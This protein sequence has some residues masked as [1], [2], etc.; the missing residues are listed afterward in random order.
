MVNFIVCEDEKVLRNET[1]DI[2]DSLMMNYDI[3]YKIN[4]FDGYNNKFEEI[5]KKDTG[6]KIYL[7]D[8]KTKKGSGIDAARIIREQYDDWNS[9]IILI[10]SYSEYKYEALCS[11]LFLLDYIN[12]L[13]NCQK[14]IKEDLVIAMKHYDNKCNM[15]SYEYNHIYY[16]VEYRQMI[17]IEKEPDSKRCII[18]TTEGKQTIP[19]T[20]NEIYDKLDNRFLKVHKSMVINL[21]Q[22]KKYEIGKNKITFK[23]GDHTHLISRNMKKELIHRVSNN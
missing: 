21:D 6:F 12:K 5:V 2:I 22:I 10:T 18:K 15:L 20:L 3:D 17:Y 14:K 4:E 19:G 7:L 11:R 23:N 9:V 16:K 13:D 1:K 8:I